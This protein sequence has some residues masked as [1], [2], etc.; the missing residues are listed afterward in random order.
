MAVHS[1]AG[2]HPS[3]HVSEKTFQA[4]GREILCCTLRRP[5]FSGDGRAQR[6][7][8]RCYA[9]LEET[10]LRYAART[11]YPKAARAAESG[12]LSA[13]WK[14]SLDYAVTLADA[15]RLSL[16]WEVTEHSDGTRPLIHRQGDT[17]RLADGR[18]IPP[19]SL[20]PRQKHIR[21]SLCSAVEE[22]LRHRLKDGYTLLFP[23][24]EQRLKRCF[25]PERFYLTDQGI[26]FFFPLATVAPFIEGILTVPISG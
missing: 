23:D 9:A 15:E 21:R 19:N 12:I 18:P 11:L 6:R 4:Q 3:P 26:V 1:E 14:L 17:W 2:A 7:L 20:F 22:Q 24:W 5:S 8:E 16:Y 25:S 10:C 13:P